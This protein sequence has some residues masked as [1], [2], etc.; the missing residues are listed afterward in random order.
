M[1]R[2]HIHN[3]KLPRHRLRKLANWLASIHVPPP[4][5]TSAEERLLTVV[6]I[7][8]TH[9]TQPTIPPGDL[10]LHAGDLTAWGTFSEIQAQLNWL[11][12]QPHQYKVIVAGNHDLLLDSGF[13]Q[14]HPERW[15]QAKE[16]RD[17][18]NTEDEEHLKASDLEFGNV[19]I[20]CQSSTKLRFGDGE[21]S[22]YG[23]PYTPQHGLSAFQYP[24]DEDIWTGAVPSD[25]DIILTHGP[26]RSHLDGVKK[27][28]CQFLQDEVLRVKPRLVVF[29]HIHVGY[30]SEKRVYDTV[31][32]VHEKINAARAGW[33]SLCLMML[34]VLWNRLTPRRWRRLHHETTYVNAAIVEGWQDYKVKEKAI[35]IELPVARVPKCRG[36]EDDSG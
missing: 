25:T 21:V 27:S 31:H 20:L 24:R 1:E 29:G 8:D 28:G 5:A 14:G 11:N 18:S 35:I 32:T 7:S 19:R 34:Y 13:L 15:H 6:C 36:N 26:P 4:S 33:G 23:S 3:V 9:N 30:G 22:I 17:S 16:A 12:E 2:R 10:L